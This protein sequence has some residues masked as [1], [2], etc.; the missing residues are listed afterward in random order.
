MVVTAPAGF[1]KTALIANL[2]SAEPEAFA[3]HFFSPIHVPESVS[4]EFFLRNIVEQMARS[5]GRRGELPT[6]LPDL[7]ALYQQLLG[8]P[9]EH[10][11]TVILDGL[12]EVSDWN[13]GLYVGR[14]LPFTDACG[15]DCARR[16]PKLAEGYDLPSEQTR[17]VPLSGLSQEELG[18]V[19]RAAGPTTAALAADSAVLGEILR[20]TANPDKRELRADPWYARLL[21]EDLASGR[22]STQD[23]SQ[24]PSGLDRYL[25]DWWRMLR[26]A[27]GEGPAGD[28]FGML[29]VARGRLSRD[30]LESLCPGLSGGWAGDL[31]EEKVLPRIRRFVVGD[32]E[33]GFALVNPRLREYMRSRI[34]TLPAYHDRLFSFCAA[35]KENQSAYALTHYAAHLA[36]APTARVIGERSSNL[37]TTATGT[38][39]RPSSISAEPPI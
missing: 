5:H 23:L 7:K 38:K 35:W 33:Y 19:L 16:R 12:D 1:G 8:E 34:R 3:Y 13:V 11:Q 27:T 14:E 39:R 10:A 36:E 4:E 29:T 25:D 15:C 21:A 6:A 26:E 2:I 20:V 32:D 28:L 17:H 30:E 22:M 37:S 31:F 18:E 24:Q 9:V